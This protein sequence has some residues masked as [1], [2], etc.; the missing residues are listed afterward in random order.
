MHGLSGLPGQPQD[1]PDVRHQRR[2]ILAGEERSL[3]IVVVAFVVAVLLFVCYF[4]KK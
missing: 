2:A 1:H 3:V 4:Y